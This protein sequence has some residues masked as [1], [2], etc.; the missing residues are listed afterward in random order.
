MLSAKPWRTDAVFF[1]LGVQACCFFFGSVAIALL[2]KAGV[3]GF[4][5]MSDP[6]CI[7]LGTLCM[8]GATWVLMGI[9]FLPE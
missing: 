1:F 5:G 4:K 6:G 3:A 8:Q 9:F 2:Q 7:L